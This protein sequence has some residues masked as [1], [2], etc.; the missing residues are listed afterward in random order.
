M[1][2]LNQSTQDNNSSLSSIDQNQIEENN[3]QHVFDLE[4]TQ[5]SRL[6]SEV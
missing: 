2:H 1:F 4:D 5:L 6:A 3:N